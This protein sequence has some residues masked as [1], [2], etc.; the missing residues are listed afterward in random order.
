MTQDVF[1]PKL[2]E[3]FRVEVF[4]MLRILTELLENNEGQISESD[5]DDGTNMSMNNMEVSNMSSSL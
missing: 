1:D 2:Y 5:A 4:R 3:G